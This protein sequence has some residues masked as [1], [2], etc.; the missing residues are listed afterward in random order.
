M[1][2]ATLPM[3][4]KRKT[5]KLDEYLLEQLKIA[6][7]KDNTSANN[8]VETLLLNG[9]KKADVVEKDYYPKNENRGGLRIKSEDSDND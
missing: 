9:L 1:N 3:P 5:F 6:A 7:R 4:R 8:W 2:T